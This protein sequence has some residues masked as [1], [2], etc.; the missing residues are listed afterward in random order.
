MHALVHWHFIFRSSHN[1]I[2]KVALVVEFVYNLANLF[3]NW[4]GLSFFYLTFFFLVSGVVQSA[5]GDVTLSG[6]S[7]CT[8]VENCTFAFEVVKTLYLAALIAVFI[9]S[10]GNRP[11]GSK[12]VYLLIILLFAFI[13][14][15]M[16]FFGA[17]SIYKI[18]SSVKLGSSVLFQNKQ[19]RDMV[20]ATASTWGLYLVSSILHMDPWHMVTSFVQYLFFLPSFINI[21]N[22]YSFC[23]LHDV[24]W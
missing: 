14:G 16:L 24:S 8:S 21:L 13:M 2:R 15:I 1:I 19:F 5:G 22:V 11:Q 4:F 23:N 20:I 7:N 3:F 10:L 18:V 12:G 17:F 6:T 9:C